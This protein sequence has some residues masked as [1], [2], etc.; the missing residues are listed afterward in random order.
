M[1]FKIAMCQINP[2]TGD[3]RGNT[4]QII[5]CIRS[6]VKD[7]SDIVVLPELAITGYCC[8]AM[9]EQK[10]FVEYNERFLREEIVPLVKKDL[11]CVV[12]FVEMGEQY[13]NGTFQRFN[14]CAVIQ[15]GE[16]VNIY[17]KMF[18]ANDGHHEDMK[19]FTP[20]SQD[21]GENS[22]TTSVTHKATHRNVVISTLICEDIWPSHDDVHIDVATSLSKIL[23]SINHSYFYYGKENERRSLVGGIAKK[24]NTPV[25]YLNPV[26]VGD[27][28]KNVMVYDGN[29]FI[30]NEK[31]QVIFESIMPSFKQRYRQVVVGDNNAFLTASQED[32]YSSIFKALTYT[33]K[34]FYRLSGLSKA[35]VHVSG[36]LDSAIGACLAAEAMGPENCVF[37][38]N[39][40]KFNGEETR[41]FAQHIADE[42]NVNLH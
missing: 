6:A 38:S 27:I 5:D 28:V 24:Y 30:S 19:Y 18:L 34:E 21:P 29:S 23:I 4:D 11:V 25:V 39:P 10:T 42:L 33:L 9:F 13:P 31:G 17:R 3:L 35:Q 32:K 37:I 16:I 41:V 2:V 40:T 20:G 12:G 14:S 36:G 26:G 7:G 8:G 1:E 22:Y 15:N